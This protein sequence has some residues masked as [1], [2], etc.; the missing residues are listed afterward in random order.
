MNTNDTF[1]FTE[2]FNGAEHHY[3]IT[4]NEAGYR[5]DENGQHKAEFSAERKF[6]KGELSPQAVQSVSGWIRARY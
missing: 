6:V 2:V 3:L 4:P 5:V 1:H